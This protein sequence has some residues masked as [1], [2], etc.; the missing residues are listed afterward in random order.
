MDLSSPQMRTR[1]SIVIEPLPEEIWMKILGTLEW[2][3][4]LRVRQCCRRLNRVSKDRSVWLSVLL[5]YYDTALPRP[6]LLPKPLR[7][8]DSTDLE[9]VICDWFSTRG[10][11][12]PHQA[13]KKEVMPPDTWSWGFSLGPLPGGRFFMHATPDGNIHCH[14][15]ENLSNPPSMF[16]P[17]PFPWYKPAFDDLP[18]LTRLS[19]D[20]LATQADEIPAEDRLFPMTFNLAAIWECRHLVHR[21]QAQLRV[22][23]VYQVE[24]QLGDDG[25]V[26]GYT[27]RELA[28]F[29]ERAPQGAMLGRCS[30]YGNHLAYHSQLE[31]ST[32]I[33][34]VDWTSIPHLTD[35]EFPRVYL[36]DIY[37]TEISLLPGK[38]IALIQFDDILIYNWGDVPS[39]THPPDPDL[40]Y[41]LQPPSP[42]WKATLPSFRGALPR[43]RPY[44]FKESIRL[45][46][47]TSVGL[48]GVVIPLQFLNRWTDS[49]ATASPSESHPIVL[50]LMAGKFPT[51]KAKQRYGFRK[52]ISLSYPN[53]YVG[54]YSWP[55]ESQTERWKV[56]SLPSRVYDAATVLTIY[57]F[58]QSNRLV[59]VESSR[60]QIIDF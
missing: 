49:E 6:F 15:I 27:A 3:E 47:P 37:N 2:H 33:A 8:S 46:I 42:K 40:L 45:V 9:R 56:S 12:D 60:C 20:I 53:T 24:V 35:T 16:I 14:D 54:R 59:S 17:T 29:R 25:S 50:Q 5:R 58:E 19:L 39:K 44:L 22:F 18:I 32:A 1:G 23:G 10:L 48:K 51:A 34:I 4:I 26:A 41:P 30:L 21:T 13:R 38:H 57:F 55:D 31:Q 36:T 28:L 52:G 11:A 7:H 43:L